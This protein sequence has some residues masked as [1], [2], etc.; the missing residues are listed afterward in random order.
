MNYLNKDLNSLHQML[1]NKEISA[2]DLVKG[3]LSN[4]K[5]TDQEIDA[6]NNLNDRAVEDAKAVDARGIDANNILDGIPLALKDNIVTKELPTTAS[7]NMLK[8]FT[9]IYD[10]TVAKKLSDLGSIN[11]GKTNMDEFAMGS[12][13]EN[14]AFKT[15]HNPWDYSK[16]P[17]GSSGGSA[18]AVASGEV[19]VALGSDTGGSIRQP[20][21]FT[22]IVGMKP[23]YGRVSRWGLIA[24][25]S[26]FDQIGPLTKNVFDNAL[27]LNAISGHDDHDSTSSEKE[28]P[29]FTEHIQDGVKGMKIGIPKEYVNKL[30]P[31]VSEAIQNAAE[32]FKKLGAQVD[33][34][35]MP[36]SKYGVTAYNALQ[37]AEASSNLERFDG[38]RY[39]YRASDAKTLDELYIKSRSEGFGDEVKRRIML[40]TLS[41]SYD[42]V[43]K[44]YKQAA[45][46][47]TLIINDFKKVFADH[48]LILSPTSRVTAFTIGV[49]DQDPIEMYMNDILTIPANMAGVPAM[50]QIA[51]F[52]NSLPIGMQLM[53]KPFDESTIYKAGYAFEQNTDFHKQ[54]PKMGGK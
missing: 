22:G 39:G 49:E 42:N 37:T 20:A 18:A 33:W 25:A 48:D 4:I 36:N 1:V 26:S 2:V 38:I 54:T 45:K 15:T 53:G 35:S 24:M 3:T 27:V 9:S 29:D 13:T 34:V 14:S 52:S 19:P 21:S 12:S 31:D 17:G 11:V 5:D 6:F 47:R 41:L 16:V 7:S 51:G 46:I 40:G 50:S 28:V 43:D 23:T 44:Y 30:A 10:A 32:T 8:N